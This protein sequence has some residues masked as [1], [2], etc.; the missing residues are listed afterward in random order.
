MNCDRSSVSRDDQSLWYANVNYMAP[1]R[2]ESS[3]F[4]KNLGNDRRWKNYHPFPFTLKELLNYAYNFYDLIWYFGLRRKYKRREIIIV[5]LPSA[6]ADT[7]NTRL[8]LLPFSQITCSYHTP[9][10]GVK[11]RSST[12]CQISSKRKRRKIRQDICY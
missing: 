7:V 1:G 11:K 5:L 8:N 10:P 4:V 12:W 2:R 3:N 6:I 9:R